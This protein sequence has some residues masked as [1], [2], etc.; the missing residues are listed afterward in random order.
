MAV[1]DNSIASVVQLLHAL[2]DEQ[3]FLD[4]QAIVDPRTHVVRGAEALV[5][6]QHP[7]HG[8]VPPAA[9]LATAT[10]GGLGSLITDFVLESAVAQCAR[11][12][13][14][15]YDIPVSVNVSA[16]AFAGPDLP[17]AVARVL[18]QHGVPPD[19]LTVEITEHACAVANG[20]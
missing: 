16:A 18:E 17:T 3:L 9:F 20:E 12:R 15:G 6:W 19:R 4:F 5:R 13:I 2:E 8:V 11:W 7:E 14:Q 1:T 10:R